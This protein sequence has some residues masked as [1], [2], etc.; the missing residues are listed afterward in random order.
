MLRP[1]VLLH[2]LWAFHRASPLG[3]HHQVPA[4]YEAVWPL[5]QPDLHRLVVPSFARRA[6]RGLTLTLHVIRGGL[7]F[8]WSTLV[9]TNMSL[10][11]LSRPQK[12]APSFERSLLYDGILPIRPH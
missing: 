7:M 2:P 9:N 12:D 6:V 5:P 8:I 11:G 10:Y 1:A 4:S 3:S